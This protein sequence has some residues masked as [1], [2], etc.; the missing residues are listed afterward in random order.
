MNI[1]NTIFDRLW[2]RKH[3]SYTLY[4]YILFSDN[5][6]FYIMQ[7]KSIKNNAVYEIFMES[8]LIKMD[9][10]ALFHKHNKH[11]YESNIPVMDWH[12]V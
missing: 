6:V 11:K 3:A 5:K 4:L 9:L 7:S 10:I 8:N 12:D 1:W 2:N